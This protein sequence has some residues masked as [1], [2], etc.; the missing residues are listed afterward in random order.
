MARDIGDVLRAHASAPNTAN[1]IG[2][3]LYGAPTVIAS[4]RR[5]NPPASTV[6]VSGLLRRYAPRNDEERLPIKSSRR[7]V[8]EGA[9]ASDGTFVHAPFCSFDVTAASIIAIT[10]MPSSMPGTR[11]R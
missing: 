10:A 1:F 5:S 9:S 4:R 2:K 8:A 11:A 7:Q 3:S 6:F